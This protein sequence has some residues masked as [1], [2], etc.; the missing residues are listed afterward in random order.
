MLKVDTITRSGMRRT[1]TSTEAV[2]CTVLS[3]SRKKSSVWVSWA[4]WPMGFFI[5][6]DVNKLKRMESKLF[7]SNIYLNVFETNDN[8]HHTVRTLKSL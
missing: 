7:I 6:V 8:W 2:Y 3:K 5:S 4:V 1:S